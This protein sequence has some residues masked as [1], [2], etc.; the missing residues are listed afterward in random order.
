MTMAMQCLILISIAITSGGVKTATLVVKYEKLRN[1]GDCL[2]VATGTMYMKADECVQVAGVSNTDYYKWTCS[3]GAATLTRYAANDYSTLWCS[4]WRQAKKRTQYSEGQ[5]L[6]GMDANLKFIKCETLQCEAPALVSGRMPSY[7]CDDG[8][9]ATL[10]TTTYD[11]TPGVATLV[12]LAGVAGFLCVCILIGVVA[13]RQKKKTRAANLAVVPGVSSV[14]GVPSSSISDPAAEMQ[15]ISQEIS[16]VVLGRPILN[17]DVL[18]QVQP[19]ITGSS[20]VVLGLPSIPSSEPATSTLESSKEK[21]DVV[22]E[23]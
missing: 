9:A 8:A 1:E 19:S 14:S 17:S 2:G 11:E 22:F 6:L 7:V 12:V 21:A 13:M 3:E 18:E 5:C 10:T 23:V 15:Q 20:D 4:A 16:D